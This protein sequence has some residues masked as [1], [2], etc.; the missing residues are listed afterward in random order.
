MKFTVKWPSLLIRIT[1]SLKNPT[2]TRYIISGLFLLPQALPVQT[3]A[4][5]ARNNDIHLP[6][7]SRG[8]GGED[9]YDRDC[10]FGNDGNGTGLPTLPAD[11]YG[12]SLLPTNLKGRH[13][14]IARALRLLRAGITPEEAHFAL[15]AGCQAIGG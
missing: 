2:M 10:H 14:I 12:P 9:E 7:L 3:S 11:C 4:P 5:I 1:I 8:E 13:D 15:A 6:K